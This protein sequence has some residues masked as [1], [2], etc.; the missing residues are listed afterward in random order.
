MDNNITPWIEHLNKPL[1]LAGFILF[2]LAGLVKLFKPEKL[3][4]A[5]TERLM[6]RGMLLS[7]VL[8]LLIVLFAFAGSFLQVQA[9]MYRAAASNHPT[10]TQT[11]TNSS[12]TQTQAGKDAYVNQGTGTL[13]HPVTPSAPANANVTQAID[14]STGVQT[15]SGGDAHTQT[16]GQ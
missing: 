12:G 13:S 15:Q 6:S 8:G 2:V 14:G 4:G 5:A 9:D 7:F 3:N 16:T 1:V 10:V 11:I